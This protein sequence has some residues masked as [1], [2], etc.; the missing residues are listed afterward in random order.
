MKQRIFWSILLSALGGILLLGACVVGLA[1]QDSSQDAWESLATKAYYFAGAIEDEG[2]AYLEK[3]RGYSGRVTLVDTDGTVLFDDR[4]LA[5]NM[6]NHATRPE[7]QEAMQTGVG[8]EERV[9]D[10]LGERTLYYALRLP[11]GQVLRTAET[12]SSVIGESLRILPWVLAVIGVLAVA[13]TLVARWQT[14]AIVRPINK[15]DLNHPLE[16]EAYGELAPLLRRISA[17]KSQLHSQVEEAKRRRDEFDTITRSMD[18]GLV[19]L[20]KDGRVLTLNERVRGILDLK[21]TELAGRHIL[22]LSRNVLLEKAV[23]GAAEGGKVRELIELGGKKYQVTAS[24]SMFDG[25]V[26]GIVLLFLDETDRVLAEE[27]RREFSANVSHELKTP[28]TSI[29][30]YAEIIHNGLAKHEDARQFAGRIYEEAN[31]LVSLVE[32]IIRLSRL[33]EKAEGLAREPVDLYALAQ[34]TAQSLAKA[35]ADAGLSIAVRGESAVVCGVPSILGEVMYNLLDN[36][37]RYSDKGAITLTVG[38]DK[39]GKAAAVSVADEGIGIPKEQQGQVFERFYRVD[40]SHSRDS[41]G[42]GLG[43]AIVKRGVMYHGGSVGLQSELG[44][45]SVF[46]FSI[47]AGRPQE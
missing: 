13:A 1:Y 34:T 26:Q 22:M 32:D 5:A 14:G 16:E 39:D 9:S 36:A 41:G 31:R 47:P 27:K 23:R 18:E 43:L 30:G 29:S 8:Q 6:E 45:G 44:R 17:Q 42:T 19:V 10:T 28:L 46:T 24:P 11:S 40:K 35:A 7:I 20:D 33:D 21:D 2:T 25:E 3:I 38:V 4:E 37:I 15:L 12:E